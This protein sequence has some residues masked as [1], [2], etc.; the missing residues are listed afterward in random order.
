MSRQ[1]VGVLL[2]GLVAVPAVMLVGVSAGYF[3]FTY[4]CGEAETRLAEA[5]AAD[6]VLDAGP[7]DASKGELYKECDDDDLF[8]SVGTEYPYSAPRQNNPGHYI[9][10]AQAKGWQ[11]LVRSE[12]DSLPECFTKRIDGTTAYLTVDGTGGG[13]RLEITADRGGS[14][15]C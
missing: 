5:M 12:D 4:G 10:A 14:E 13:T 8:V 6:P 2:A 7:G 1:R 15:W 11:S 9:E 3:T